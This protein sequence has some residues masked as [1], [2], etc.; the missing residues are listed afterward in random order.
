MISSFEWLKQVEK[1]EGETVDLLNTLWMHRKPSVSHLSLPGCLEASGQ[2]K[3]SSLLCLFLGLTLAESMG[4]YITADICSSNNNGKKK[5]KNHDW[6]LQGIIPIKTNK[7]VPEPDFVLWDTEKTFN[8][9]NLSPSSKRNERRGVGI[10][11][12]KAQESSG[13]P[14][15]TVG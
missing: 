10:S 7:V 15:W 4:K 14:S 9:K 3:S 2:S 13:M 5:T 6:S 11:T 1:R 12:P 8:L